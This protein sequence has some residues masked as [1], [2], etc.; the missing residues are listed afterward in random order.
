MNIE[1]ELHRLDKTVI[2]K[3]DRN[4]MNAHFIDLLLYFQRQ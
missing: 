2:G 4:V 3:K 1:I